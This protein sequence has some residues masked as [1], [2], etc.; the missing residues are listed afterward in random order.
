MSAAKG[1]ALTALQQNI[2]A[3]VRL[4][5]RVK[6]IAERTRSRCAGI[7]HPAHPAQTPWPAQGLSGR[8][9]H[10]DLGGGPRYKRYQIDDT[11]H[12]YETDVSHVRYC[13]R[14]GGEPDQTRSIHGTASEDTMGLFDSLFGSN[15]G[16]ARIARFRKS[17]APT[18]PDLLRIAKDRKGHISRKAM[19]AEY[20]RLV[21]EKYANDKA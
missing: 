18:D 15:P 2:P 16:P 4:G 1:L 9:P 8:Q 6:L 17:R 10:Q 5:W 20:T 3:N 19:H 12:S 14:R 7:S 21:L 13:H 11:R